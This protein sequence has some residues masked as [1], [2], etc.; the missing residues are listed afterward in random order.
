MAETENISDVAQRVAKDI[1]K[2]FGWHMHPKRNDNFSCLNGE[3][4]SEKGK[5]KK[6]HPTDVVFSYDDPYLGIRIHLLTD[7]KSYGSNSITSLSLRVALRSLAFSVECANQSE[8]WKG[9]FGVLTDEQHEV[10]GLLFVHNHDKG[11]EKNFY[12]E[13]RKVN[14]KTLPIAAGNLL[15]YLGPNDINRLY[16]IANDIKSLRLEKEISDDY[17]FFYPDLVTRHRVGDV[18]N[19]AATIEMMAGPF[20]I[21]RHLGSEHASAGYVIYYNREGNTV[22]EFEYL[23]DFFSR[24]QMLESGVG[25]RVRIAHPAGSCDMK[26][27]FDTAVAK[28]IR[29]CGFDEHRAQILQSMEIERISA[30]VNNYNPGDSGWRTS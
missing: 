17:T 16:S 25:I 21:L 28:Y 8:E 6:T 10:R 9:K 20:M 24:F 3:H 11:Y 4:K 7:L 15:H 2:H 30:I 27:H 1:F 18:W 5:A 14:T 22:Q 12:E 26:S 23:I 13:L 19:Q 29:A